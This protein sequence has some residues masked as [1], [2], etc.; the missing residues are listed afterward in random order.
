MNACGVVGV[1]EVESAK[2][3][4]MIAGGAFRVG[5]KT[6]LTPLAYITS[7][8]R[9]QSAIIVLHGPASGSN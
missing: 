1:A 8:T 3:A 5:Q 9:G 7:G 2:Q 6:Q 4:G